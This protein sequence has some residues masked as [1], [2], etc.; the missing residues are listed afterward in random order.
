MKKKCALKR[1][2]AIA[3]IRM[4]F[5]IIMLF[6]AFQKLKSIV[7]YTFV[8]EIIF[9]STYNLSL[10][11]DGIK[12]PLEFLRKILFQKFLLKFQESCTREVI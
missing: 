5:N 1:F 3:L 12:S 8:K 7:K 6:K 10:Y 4:P 2:Y 9:D 11:F